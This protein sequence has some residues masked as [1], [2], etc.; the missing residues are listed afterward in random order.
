MSAPC[1]DILGRRGEAD[2]P[3]ERARYETLLRMAADPK[4]RL[5]VSLG[6]GSLPGVCG[7]LALLSILEELHLRGRVEEVW[8]TSAGAAVGGPW[9]AG[10]SAAEIHALARKLDRP[11]TIDVPWLKLALAFLKKPFGGTLPDG[12]VKGEKIAAV[13]RAALKVESF[14]QC[15]IPFRCIACTDDG[16]ARRRVFR[17]GPLFPAIFASMTLPG[18]VM[19]PALA[20]GQE[21]GYYDGGLVE[22][23]PLLSPIAEHGRSG[24]ER[25]LL[26]IAT[27]YGNDNRRQRESGFLNRFLQSMF[28][29]E[30]LAWSYQLAEA[31]ARRD[32]ALILLD[33]RIDDPELF[34]FANLERNY[35]IARQQF[36]EALEDARIGLTFGRE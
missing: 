15:A 18:I 9:A 28:A 33:P 1:Q 25:R 4:H 13:V 21:S 36:R 3:L 12:L 6:G 29:L 10:A 7:N 5:V 19:P 14:E 35:V 2:A 20:A 23:T 11:G 17:R 31:R 30:D 16:Y 34:N 8:G 26:V 27:H 32:V 24:D 22:K